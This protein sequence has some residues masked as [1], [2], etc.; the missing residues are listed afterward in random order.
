MRGQGPAAERR[1][2]G[3]GHPE[4]GRRLVHV[5]PPG[6][7]HED[8]IPEELEANP[9]L[10]DREEEAR[11][12]GIDAQGHAAG[13]AEGGGGDQG[14]DLHQHGPRALDRG[15][16]RGAGRA[17]LVLGQEEGRGIGHGLQAGTGHLEDPDF[18]NGS[19]SILR[20]A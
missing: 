9:L 15:H 11:A 6:D 3:G 5:E 14:L 20:A 1:R 10:E 16:H 13:R 17:L 19:K 4:V 18:V 12:I 8:V 7:A 2:D